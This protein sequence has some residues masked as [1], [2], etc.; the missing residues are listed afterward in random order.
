MYPSTAPLL[1][2]AA[3]MALAASA[4]LNP[5]NGTT[6]Q[7]GAKAAI[8]LD[9]LFTAGEQFEPQKGINDFCEWLGEQTSTAAGPFQTNTTV[10]TP[11]SSA[12]SSILL[13]MT[14][15]ATK[16]AP[17]KCLGNSTCQN[18]MQPM[19]MGCVSNFSD[20]QGFNGTTIA[21]GGVTDDA[22]C[23]RF[24]YNI[25]RPGTITPEK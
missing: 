18:I 12:G 13:S 15:V 6:L 19:F 4:P 20:D 23:G 3:L 1:A 22:G 14:L 2:A 11:L 16:G 10:Q 21:M 5:Q 8:P 9:L 17:M 7:C 25:T 24:S